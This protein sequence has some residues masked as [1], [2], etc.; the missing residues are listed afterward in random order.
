MKASEREKVIL[1]GLLLSK[2]GQQALERLG[3]SSFSESYNAFG[4]P[5]KA[6]PNSIK[7][8]RDEL[9]PYFPN[10]RVGWD[11]RVIRDHCRQILEE[12]GSASLDDLT[13][14]IGG[15]LDPG[16]E[17]PPLLQGSANEDDGNSSFARRL[18]TGKA[19]EEYFA[20]NFP[21]YEHFSGGELVN[22][23]QSGCGFDFRINFQASDFLAVEV[24]GLRENRCRINLT[25]KEHRRAEELGERYFLCVVSNFRDT[26][27]ARLWQDPLRSN[28]E[29]LKSEQQLTIP[30]W[31]SS[32]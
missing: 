26:P 30:T 21:T 17:L 28:L 23:T 3:F 16:F 7:G 20:T 10:Q 27:T 12:H 29:W 32:V 4:A 8:Y 6:K 1:C 5:L 19:A 24:K 11:K 15:F 2:F 22:T 31:S 13:T 18:I 25:W 9:D 14:L